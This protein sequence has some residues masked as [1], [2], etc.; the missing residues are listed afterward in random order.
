MNKRFFGKAGRK[1]VVLG[2]DGVPFSLLKDYLG[3][4][5]LPNIGRILDGDFRLEPMDASVPEVSSTSWTSFMT[6]VNPGEHGIYGFMELHPG[7][8]RVYFPNFTDV[9]APTVWEILGGSAG[10]KRSSLDGRYRDAIAG[11]YRSVVL[12]LPQT[13]PAGPINGV[14]TAGFVAPD[15]K[16]AT[17][18]DEA[19]RY[20]QSIGYESDV[21]ASKAIDETEVFLA[22]LSRALEKRRIA[23]EHF[24]E[25]EEWDLFIGTITETDRLHHFF[26]D[27]ALDP[28]HPRHQAFVS[29]YRDLDSLIGII[30]DKF[31]AMTDGNGLFM[32]LSDH[33][34]ACIRQE[35][36]VNQWLKREGYLKTDPGRPYFDQI[37]HG[38]RAFALDPGRIY[39]NVKG[40]YPRGAVKPDDRKK[41]MEEIRS[42]ILALEDR[43]GNR[44]VGEVRDNDALYSGPLKNKGPDLVLVPRDG[45]DM[46]G[47]LSKT[48]VMGMERFTGMHTGHDAH[49]ILPAALAG[50]RRLHV[51]D[52]AGRILDHFAGGGN[53]GPSF[54]A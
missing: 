40:K 24:M 15:L 26:F 9:K 29:L 46:K 50:G 5:M 35:I 27:A 1:A 22:D 54:G 49:C 16:K 12:N 17:Y 2:L 31:M 45:Y 52:M 19:Y 14:L 25:S 7:T 13:Y 34:F 41:V 6:G 3:R 53:D 36:Y 8:Y 48:E 21:D 20:L 47:T 33:G 38:T 51:E 10:A 37:D 23:F 30:H 43:D 39:I 11:E 4:G 44:V 32:T 18:P 28:A 42:G